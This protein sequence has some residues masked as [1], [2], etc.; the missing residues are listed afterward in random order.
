MNATIPLFIKV[1]LLS[2][3]LVLLASCGL[4]S[5]ETPQSTTPDSAYSLETILVYRS[6][7]MGDNSNIINLFNSLPNAEKFGKQF[8]LFPDTHSVKVYYTPHAEL[9]HDDR[10]AMMLYNATA[11]FAL[12]D[13]LEEITFVFPQMTH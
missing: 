6:P 12:I 11:A 10:M 7:Y 13:N 5:K 9:S 1:L 4:Q 8:E 2:A 3:L